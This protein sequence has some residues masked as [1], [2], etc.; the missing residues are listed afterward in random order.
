MI[1]KVGL[2]YYSTV[3]N[4]G[5]DN[6]S[7]LENI[8][9][10]NT[11]TEK[12]QHR[13]SIELQTKW[14]CPVSKENR[15]A[16]INS[17][18][19]FTDKIERFSK[20][21]ELYFSIFCFKK[22][23]DKSLTSSQRE[24]CGIVVGTG[25]G[26]TTAIQNRTA[27]VLIDNKYHP[28][29]ILEGMNNNIP[30]LLSLAHKISGPSF[31][32]QSACSS[33][34]NA[35]LIGA[36]LISLGIID[37]CICG[38]VEGRV[39]D[40]TFKAWDL[41]RVMSRS[42][43]EPNEMIKPFDKDRDGFLIGEG[44]GYILLGDTKKL[45]ENNYPIYATIENFSMNNN[46]TH[47]TRPD[48]ESQAKCISN[49]IKSYK[50]DSK[51]VN[52]I[53]AHGSATTANDFYEIGSINKAFGDNINN[54]LIS[55]SKSFFGHCFGASGAMELISVL[56]SLSEGYLPPTLNLLNSEFPNINFIPQ[57]AV[58]KSVEYFLKNSFG[59]GGHN[60]CLLLKNLIQ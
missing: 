21:D 41:M 14:F 43:A 26:N 7:I 48:M 33:S 29:A 35:I 16:I 49:C 46:I 18:E 17:V 44:A 19:G 6:K 40:I 31:V 58:K 56:L 13:D 39:S 32:V 20:S 47:L 60:I 57:K 12:F 5:I 55:S 10:G 50:I 52:Y 59:F 8:I 36:N 51:K 2:S 30:G 24:R 54:I 28:M 11:Y 9:N 37:Y 27:S 42:K 25:S 53:N 34:L 4:I 15:A 38:G 1:K 45:K 3:S 22:I 23:L